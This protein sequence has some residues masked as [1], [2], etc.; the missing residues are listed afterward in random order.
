[1]TQTKIYT[2]A[3]VK[4][5]ILLA[6]NEMGPDAL[7]LDTKQDQRGYHVTFAMEAPAVEAAQPAAPSS[8]FQELSRQLDEIRRVLARSAQ[9][10][11]DAPRSIPELTNLQARLVAAE[12]A[13]AL[14]KDI[15]DRVEAALAVEGVCHRAALQSRSRASVR[16]LLNFDYDSIEKLM[17]AEM[18]R[19]VRIDAGIRNR[20]AVFVGPTGAGKTTSM[21]KL[22][23]ATGGRVRLMS[24]DQ[25]PGAREEMKLYASTCAVDFVPLT[26]ALKLPRMLQSLKDADLIM[27]DTPGMPARESAEASELAEALSQCPGADV[28]LVLPGYMK[29]SDLHRAIQRYEKFRFNKLLITKLDETGALGSVFSE[30]AR[31][32]TSF[33]FLTDGTRIPEDIR[34]A[35]PDEILNLVLRGAAQEEQSAA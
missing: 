8:E 14:A 29:S 26:S 19:R 5:A 3:T 24:L 18:K 21:V 32:G 1:V 27:L 20:L 4:E 10:S 30:A 6:R 15:I 12:V 23:M 28:F 11:Q 22:A 31:F 35:T 2:A 33:S 13:P 34:A 16:M 9:P 7:L 17:L 25:T